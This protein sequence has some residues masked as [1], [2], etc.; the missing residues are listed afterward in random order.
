MQSDR[1]K[2]TEMVGARIRSLRSAR[3][4]SIDALAASSEI[5]PTYLG[6]IE[7]GE[8]CPT[9]DTLDKVSMGLGLPLALHGGLMRR[10]AA[11]A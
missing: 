6:R 7:R 4:L 2:L 8:K 11:A 9:L 1:D 5:N 10:Q 3:G